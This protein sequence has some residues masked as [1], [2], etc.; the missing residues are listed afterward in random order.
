MVAEFQQVYIVACSF[1]IRPV[2]EICADSGRPACEQTLIKKV[3]LNP[4]QLNTNRH[5][6]EEAEAPSVSRSSAHYLANVLAAI[7]TR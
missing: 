5:D 2:T 3:S 7:P 6:S 1:T 4:Q